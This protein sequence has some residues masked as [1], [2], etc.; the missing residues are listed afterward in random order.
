MIKLTHTSSDFDLTTDATLYEHK[1]HMRDLL[2]QEIALPQ[3]CL[4]LEQHSVFLPRKRP[5]YLHY[6]K[7]QLLLEINQ[8]VSL[9]HSTILGVQRDLQLL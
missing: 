6:K 1:K 5:L 4:Q 3:P 7:Y 9:F 8:E 2:R